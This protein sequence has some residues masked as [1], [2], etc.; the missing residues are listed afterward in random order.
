VLY[1]ERKTWKGTMSTRTLG[2]P[3][4][5]VFGLLSTPESRPDP[6][7]ARPRVDDFPPEAA[8]D[9]SHWLT[10]NAACKL[11]GVDQ[12]TLR[13]WSDAG[14]VP[15]FRTPGGHRRY[16]EEALRAMIGDGPRR[17][18]RPR[19][20]RQTLTERSMAGYEDEHMASARERRWYRAYSPAM[21][22]DLR[23]HGR[24]LIELAGR[25]VTTPPGSADRACALGEARQIG[26]HY[27]RVSA[28]AGLTVAESVEAFHYFRVPVIRS[29]IG[30]TDDEALAAKRAVRVH[31]ELGQ[32]LDEVLITTVRSHEQCLGS[33]C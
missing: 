15:V 20:T 9:C 33:R 24:R 22:E 8:M 26:E 21:L 23:R 28:N 2:Q 25:F 6:S 4:P 10:I 7:V 16:S 32:F 27:G 11:L 14:K 30:L 12:S 3:Q 29:I 18:T 13:R 31:V 17:Q 19:L 5:R 1:G